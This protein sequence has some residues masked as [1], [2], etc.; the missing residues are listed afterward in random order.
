MKAD[1]NAL[2]NLGQNLKN[3]KLIKELVIIDEG[4]IEFFIDIIISIIYNMEEIYSLMLC[5]KSL[6]YSCVQ[7]DIYERYNILKKMKYLSKNNI[8]INY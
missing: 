8:Y 6:L 2:I 1:K 5:K 4:M 3:C 7:S